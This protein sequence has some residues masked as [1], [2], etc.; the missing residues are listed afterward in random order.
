MHLKRAPGPDDTPVMPIHPRLR[1]YSDRKY[2]RKLSKVL[3]ALEKDLAK[4]HCPQFTVELIEENDPRSAMD[5]FLSFKHELHLDKILHVT[6]RVMEREV[7][8]FVPMHKHQLFPYSLEIG[9]NV[10]APGVAV[11]EQGFV[12]KHWVVEP[13]N[14]RVLR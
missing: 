6:T 4:L 12:K 13:K 11:Y 1:D 5:R 14:D 7:S 9:L 2:I 8:V 3:G 10:E